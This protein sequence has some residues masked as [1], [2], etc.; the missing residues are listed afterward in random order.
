MSNSALLP[1]A[2]RIY[3]YADGEYHSREFTDFVA[4]SELWRE[5]RHAGLRVGMKGLM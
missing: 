2:V 3:W 1:V 5:L 4:A